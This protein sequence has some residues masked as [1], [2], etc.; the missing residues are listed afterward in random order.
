MRR[1]WGSLGDVIDLS[2]VL[3]RLTVEGP[4][5]DR[6]P[7]AANLSD[8]VDGATATDC[9]GMPLSGPAAGWVRPEWLRAPLR[10]EVRALMTLPPGL[11]LLAALQQVG[12]GPVCP[13]DHDAQGSG[14]AEDRDDTDTGLCGKPPVPGRTAGWPCGCQLIVAA[15]WE[16]MTAWVGMRGADALVAAA[17]PQPMKAVPPR[18]G[19]ATVNDPGR[20]EVAAVLALSPASTDTRLKAA[21]RL[22][23][24]PELA[25]LARDGVLFTPGIR[26]ILEETANL[27]PAAQSAVIA[28]ACERV[29][30]RRAEG[31][32]PWTPGELRLA[33]KRMV[34]RLAADELVDAR[35]KARRR[36]RVSV[37]PDVDGMAWL[38]ALISDVDAHRIH[39]RLSAA[40][41]ADTADANTA[42][43]AAKARARANGPA[44]NPDRAAG[45]DDRCMDERRADLLVEALLNCRGRNT[46]TPDLNDTGDARPARDHHGRSPAHDAG[47]D[48]HAAADPASSADPAEVDRQGQGPLRGPRPGEDIDPHGGMPADGPHSDAASEGE[49]QVAGFGG[50][51]ASGGAHV[52]PGNGVGGGG[53]TGPVPRAD[54]PEIHVV[55]DVHTLLGLANDPAHVHGMGPI[56]AQVARELAADGRWR[57]LVTDPASGQVA[58]T[59]AR[60]YTPTAGLAR[61]IRAREP[62]CRMPGCARQAVNCDLD[63]TQPWPQ[64][65]G[66]TESNLGPLC[67]RCH[68]LKTH[69]GFHL[70]NREGNN[71]H[72]TDPPSADTEAT[73][74]AADGPTDTGGGRPDAADNARP[75][76]GG[77]TWTFPSGLTHTDQPEPPLPD[78]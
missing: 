49:G 35:A 48:P 13:M 72:G 40:A 77:W 78:D 41:A 15:G 58:A 12:T 66:T 1:C 61:L 73:D 38:S 39:H 65:P 70:H 59:S 9:T 23:A 4:L 45:I 74:P 53:S 69:H 30:A 17:G 46:A 62:V 18:M 32:R 47:V 31:R 75:N 50:G 44:A 7:D 19:R 56:P 60:T 14:V 27:S 2:P 54:R 3:R 42:A 34:L 28:R 5:P 55:V 51:P 57:L 64:P 67:R 6:D 36:R 25:A 24:H 52:W 8:R 63:H 10:A 68:N 33:V 26:V 71:S 37:T 21:R 20:N 43:A 22:T 11:E 76:S 29:R 16:A